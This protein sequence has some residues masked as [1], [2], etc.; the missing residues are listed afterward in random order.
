M[1]ESSTSKDL[2]PYL[3]TETEF[4][5]SAEQRASFLSGE[6]ILPSGRCTEPGRLEARILRIMT[7]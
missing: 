5:G 3:D 1:E 6:N 7:D 2:R 4:R